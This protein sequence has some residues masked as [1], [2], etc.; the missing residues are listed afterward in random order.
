MATNVAEAH[1]I[2][3]GVELVCL[4]LSYETAAVLE[5]G[6]MP[7][8]DTWSCQSFALGSSFISA[9]VP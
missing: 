5:Q 7:P 1:C 2:V 4:S 9:R 8:K 3:A 6:K